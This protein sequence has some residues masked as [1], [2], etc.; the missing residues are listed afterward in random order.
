MLLLLATVAFILLLPMQPALPRLVT[1]A[2]T[3]MIIAAVVV[4]AETRRAVWVALA[5]AAPA[6]ILPWISRSDSLTALSLTGSVTTSLLYLF[7]L[8]LMLKR[9]FRTGRVT[10]ET[11]LLAVTSYLMTAIVW[12]IGYMIVELASPGAF[13]CFPNGVHAANWHLDMVYFSFVTMSTL[14]YG[15]I[16]PVAPFARSLATL[17]AVTGTMFLGVLIAGL[18]ARLGA[19]G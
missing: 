12:S 14:G 19:R 8:V 16:V 13:S 4:C 5:L 7:V 10:L 17:E 18:V 2:G 6:A 15:D 9:V 1:A 3:T 11:V